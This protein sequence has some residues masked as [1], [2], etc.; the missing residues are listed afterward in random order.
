MD[1][2]DKSLLTYAVVFF[3]FIAG[4]IGIG[5]YAGHQKREQLH[6]HE[7]DRMRCMQSKEPH[8]V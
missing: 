2:V 1:V 7:M 4:V 8:H 5:M 6:R 3:L